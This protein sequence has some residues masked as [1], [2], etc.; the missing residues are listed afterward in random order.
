MKVE[1]WSDVVCPFCYIGKT[2]FD[3]ALAQFAEKENIEFVWKS[4]QLNPDLTTNPDE[5]LYQHLSES[6]DIPLEQA[7]AMGRHA[8]QMGSS[9]GL[10]LNFDKCVVANSFN[11]H[12]LIHF[13][14]A[15]G[16]QQEMKARLFKAYFTEGSNIDDTETLIALA[17]EIGLNAEEAKSVLE[18]DKYASDVNDDINKSQQLGVRGVPF[19]VFDRK[20]A[21]SGAQPKEAFFTTLEKSFAEWRKANPAVELQVSE[22]AVCEPNKVCD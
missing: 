4:F 10:E 15:N 2:H 9:A 3:E 8:A 13:A 20:Y 14:K 17:K 16:K 5:S 6:K 12:R 19:F 18:S 21:V 11:A 7:K 22:G 1:V